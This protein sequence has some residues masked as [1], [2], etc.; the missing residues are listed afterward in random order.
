MIPEHI[1]VAFLGHDFKNLRSNTKPNETPFETAIRNLG[2]A[3]TLLDTCEN[4]PEANLTVVQ[5]YVKNAES[6]YYKEL[7]YKQTGYLQGETSP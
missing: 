3:Y 4:I 2:T 6:A 5:E 1:A 7:F